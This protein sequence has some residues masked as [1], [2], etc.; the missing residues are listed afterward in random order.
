MSVARR[1]PGVSRGGGLYRELY[2]TR[3]DGRRRRRRAGVADEAEPRAFSRR[4]ETQMGGVIVAGD[5][6]PC[7]DA[8]SDDDDDD[9][10]S[11]ATDEDAR[12][13]PRAER[14][15]DDA[16]AAAPRLRAR[17][18]ELERECAS[19]R[20]A[21]A[22]AAAGGGG[23]G[24]AALGDARGGAGRGAAAARIARGEQRE[25]G[26]FREGSFGM[27][28]RFPEQGGDGLG[29]QPTHNLSGAPWRSH[30]PIWGRPSPRTMGAF[31]I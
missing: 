5:A 24:G 26:F 15:G 13:A 31:A 30:D 29:A 9:A 16:A 11:D 17:V 27:P 7:G 19:L 3:T 23:G 20:A 14:D 10:A 25:L 22:R 2:A 8:A 6:A 28:A 1:A 18:A 12:A 21:L 4:Y